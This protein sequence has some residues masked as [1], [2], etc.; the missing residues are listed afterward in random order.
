MALADAVS[1]E[2]RKILVGKTGHGPSCKQSEIN[3]MI[4]SLAV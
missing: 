1:H 3:G 2:A 4:V